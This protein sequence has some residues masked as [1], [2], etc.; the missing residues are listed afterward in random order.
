MERYRTQTRPSKSQSGKTSKNLNGLDGLNSL[1]PDRKLWWVIGPVAA[2]GVWSTVMSPHPALAL[3]GL[4][5]LATYL[6]FFYLVVASVKSRKEQR[7]LVWVVTGTAAFLCVVGL[8]KRFDI[9]VFTWWDYA[10]ELGRN[11]GDTRLSGVYVNANH[12][13]G[14]LGMAIPMVLGMFLTR[15]RSPEARIGMIFLVLFLIV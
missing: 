4:I 5:M 6:G 11:H 8:L 15:S 1:T 7:T 12:M 10:P 9:L 3:Q 14:F 2:L 13:A